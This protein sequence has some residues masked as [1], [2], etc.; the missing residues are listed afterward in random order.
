VNWDTSCSSFYYVR[1]Q[2]LRIGGITQGPVR[3]C[4]FRGSTLFF[5]LSV[6]H[7]ISYPLDI[8]RNNF[9]PSSSATALRFQS[10][11]T[12]PSAMTSPSVFPFPHGSHLVVINPN[13]DTL[14]SVP[15]ADG[16]P[17]LFFA[18][19]GHGSA[20]D[21]NVLLVYAQESLDASITNGRRIWM[22][23]H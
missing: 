3:R 15:L 7:V 5:R 22:V 16:S 23:L 10:S 13:I 18:V 9:P 11:S 2:D 17:G 4:R 6:P 20:T 19:F 14:D 12:L 1:T 21:L 8:K